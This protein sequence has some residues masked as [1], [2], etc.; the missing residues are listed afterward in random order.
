MRLD[1][2]AMERAQ[3]LYEHEVRFNL[4][5][6]GVRPL[7]VDE[8]LADGGAADLGGLSLAYPPSTGS[9]LLR[10]RIAAWYPGAAPG[11]I[12]VTNGG[13]EANFT[14]L[15]G[16]LEP[17]TRV[18]VMLPNYMQAW[19]LARAWAGRADPFR[20][21]E[22]PARAAA[23]SRWALDEASLRRSVGP[24][25]RVIVVT[26]PNNPTGHVLTE[27]EIEAIVRVARRARAWLLVDEVYRGAEAGRDG[28]P[29]PVT[30]ST[31][32]GRAARVVVTAGLSKAF[33]LP[34]LRTG[35]IVAPVALQR[36]LCRYL[37]YTTLTPTALSDRLA[38]V[39]MEP[40]RR[41]AL[42]A[43][44]RAIIR[45]NLPP[46]EEWIAG[47]GGLFRYI[48][49]RAGAIAF[50]GYDMPI[51]SGRLFERLRR[52]RSVLITPGAHF[53]T[54]RYIRVGFGY[55]IGRTLEGLRQCEPVFEALRRRPGLSQRSA[56]R[57]RPSSAR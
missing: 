4:S 39:A 3:C 45:S 25:T 27:A 8:L 22:K 9:A 49:P 46:L 41:E 32:W 35:W 43:R 31:F 10:E 44:T 53:G 17:G 24:R 26:N 55:D 42:L 7:T 54:G 16:L 13:S 56:R 30:S 14:V 12:L 34:G 48:P 15:W 29:E 33:G 37:D 20:L 1:L 2:F 19:G 47:R 11:N 21:V 23:G 57:R 18:A 38:A 40:R 5:E 52:E 51:G 28:G 6:S 36:R 50:L